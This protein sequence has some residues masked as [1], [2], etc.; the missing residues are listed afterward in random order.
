MMAREAKPGESGDARPPKGRMTWMALAGI[1]L[2]AVLMLTV[3]LRPVVDRRDG[4]ETG[5]PA[6]NIPTTAAPAASASSAPPWWFFS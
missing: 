1:L 5:A 3:I 2:F 6:V 4:P